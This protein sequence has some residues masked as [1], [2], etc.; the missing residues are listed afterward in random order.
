LW[1]H[2]H[3][4]EHVEVPTLH[5]MDELPAWLAERRG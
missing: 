1:A 5:S 2:E 3:V 4:A